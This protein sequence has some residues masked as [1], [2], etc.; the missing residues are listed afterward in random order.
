[1]K[2]LIL[3]IICCFGLTVSYAQQAK[4]IKRLN[5]KNVTATELITRLNQILDSG[6]VTGLQVA[7]INHKNIAW[8]HSFGLK[9]LEKQVP[10]NDSTV[11]YAAS[12][13][14]VVFSYLFMRLVEQG[15]FDL[16]KPIHGYL[17]LPISE[18]PKWKDLGEDTASFNKITPRMILSHS[19]GLPVLRSLYGN[20]LRLIAKPGEKYYYSNEGMNLLGFIVEEYTGKGLR[21]WTREEVFGPLQ[22][23]HTSMIWEP[24]FEQ[25]FS[26]AYF[27]DGKKYG[28][29][30]RESSRAA[31]SMSTTAVDYAKFI[32]NILNKRGLSKKSYGDMLS[33]QI[34]I[35]TERGFGSRKD[36]LTTENDKIKLSRGLGPT[37]IVSPYGSA[38]FH[39]GHGE[40]NQNYF[41]AFPEKGIS[42][43]LM[44][45]SENFERVSD[46]ILEACIA[47]KYSPLTWLGHFDSH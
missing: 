22:M 38:F 23:N 41:I 16:D 8:T 7:I 29:E 44:S 34:F 33:A 46:A 14:K 18:Y 13:T 6:K 3:F 10:L 17:K 42:V 5:G 21:E 28:S 47:D 15:I 39:G 36:S 27:K 45:N 19:S 25:N 11:M 30:R 2:K 35:H 43:V 40:A 24:V 32:S 26:Y 37:L 9:N 20:K 1:M 12:L 31:G 4:M